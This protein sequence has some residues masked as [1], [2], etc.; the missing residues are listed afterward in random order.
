MTSSLHKILIFAAL[1]FSGCSSA[2]EA[3]SITM[4]NPETQ[5]TLVCAARDDRGGKNA[6]LA[7]FVEVCAR[8]LESRGF[9][10]QP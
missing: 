5:A 2:P 3:L 7:A 8:Q 10:R 6:A 4:F 1:C 9:V